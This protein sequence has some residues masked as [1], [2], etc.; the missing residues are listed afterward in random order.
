[1][2]QQDRRNP[3][4]GPESG[5]IG[6]A[7]HGKKLRDSARDGEWKNVVEALGLNAKVSKTLSF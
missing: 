4:E 2:D 6:K 7:W 3:D 5:W 1:M